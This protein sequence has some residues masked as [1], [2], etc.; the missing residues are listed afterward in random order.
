MSISY[1]FDTYS[2]EKFCNQ[3]S[4]KTHLSNQGQIWTLFSHQT[5][6]CGS[7]EAWLQNFSMKYVSKK[8]EFDKKSNLQVHWLL[9]TEISFIDRM[10]FSYYIRILLCM[11]STSS[12][13]IFQLVNNF[14]HFKSHPTSN[15]FLY[16]MDFFTFESHLR[17]SAHSV[18]YH[19]FLRSWQGA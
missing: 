19:T 17:V 7:P 8:Y 9:E 11:R 18:T 1:F 2:I 10:A 4:G 12:L 16:L 3:A 5:L 6:W 15:S 14:T 13:E